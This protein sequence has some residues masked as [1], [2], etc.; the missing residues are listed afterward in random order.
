MIYKICCYQKEMEKNPTV[1]VTPLAVMVSCPASVSP[2]ILFRITIVVVPEFTTSNPTIRLPEITNHFCIFL[3]G[4]Y[5]RF[6]MEIASVIHL[7][8]QNFSKFNTKFKIYSVYLFI[9][10]RILLLY[11]PSDGE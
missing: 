8:Q 5:S 3:K 11:V 10:V 4:T 6:K 9:H 7:L 2:M 1:S